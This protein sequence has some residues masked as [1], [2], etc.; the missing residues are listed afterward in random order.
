MS[1]EMIAEFVTTEDLGEEMEAF[2]RERVMER[3]SPNTVAT[4]GSARRL[5]AVV[6]AAATRRR[7]PIRDGRGT[8]RG[9]LAM[10]GTL[11][12]NVARR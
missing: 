7:S 2:V 12:S 5:L 3:I 11:S 1:I 9:R 8:R 10:P 4:Y 6:V